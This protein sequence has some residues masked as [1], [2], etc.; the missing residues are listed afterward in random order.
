MALKVIL[1]LKVLQVNKDHKDTQ[2]HKD[3]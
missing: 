1:A 3:A 2:V